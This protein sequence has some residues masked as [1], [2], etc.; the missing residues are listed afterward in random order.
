MEDYIYKN[1]FLLTQEQKQKVPFEA[2]WV[3]NRKGKEYIEQSQKQP[4]DFEKAIAWQKK[5]DKEAGIKNDFIDSWNNQQ[6]PTEH[7]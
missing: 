3:N 2:W 4:L 1:H 5:I 7:G 6:N